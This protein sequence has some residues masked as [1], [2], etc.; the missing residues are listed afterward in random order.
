MATNAEKEQVAYVP[1]D[2]LT[3]YPAE[4]GKPMAVSDL[5]RRQFVLDIRS[6]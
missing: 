3:L 4:D 5:H 1:T 2:A 6:T